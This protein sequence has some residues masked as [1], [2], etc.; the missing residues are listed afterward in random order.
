MINADHDSFIPDI[1]IG[2]SIYQQ[3]LSF[4]KE[5]ISSALNQDGNYSILCTIRVDGLKGCNA[6]TKEWLEQL[7]RNDARVKILFGE[8]NNGTYGSYKEIFNSSESRYICQLDADDWLEKNAIKQ[9][10]DLLEVNPISSFVYTGYNEVNKFGEFVRV[11]ARSEENFSLHRQLVQFNT[12]HLRVIRR[13]YYKLIDGY[14]ENLKF[15]GDYDLSLKLAEQAKPCYLS[16]IL[17]NYR[18]HGSNTSIR[19]KELTIKEA[20]QVASDALK[21]REQEHIWKLDY[22]YDQKKNTQ[23]V[24]LSPR[25][26][27]II[28]AGMH[29]SGTSVLALVLQKM[30]INIGDRLIKADNQNPDGYGEDQ[31]I[32]EINRSALR[33]TTQKSSQ[34]WEDWG[35]TRLQSALPKRH[36]DQIWANQAY[37]Y[38]EQRSNENQF[39]GWKDPRNTLF[40][41]DWVEIEPQSKVV[42]IYR[43]PWEITGALQRIKPPIFL[44]HPDWCLEV[45]NQYNGYLLSFL[46]KYPGRSILV[47]STSLVE[48]PLALVDLIKQ[49]W[50][51]PLANL[52]NSH[53]L[54]I[55]NLI[56]PN[57]Y[58]KLDREEELI[59]LF[60]TCSPRSVDIFKRLDNI[61]DLPSPLK[62]YDYS[63]MMPKYSSRQQI[64]LSIII[65][66]YNQG[67]MLIEALASAEKYRTLN[68]SEVLIVDDGSSDFRTC[69]VLE[70]LRNEG[71]QI[72]RQK[73]QGVSIARNKGLRYAKGDII[74]YLDDDNRLLSPYLNEGLDVMLKNQDLDVV[75]GDRTEFG[76]RSRYIEVG[77]LNSEALWSGNKIDNCALIRRRYLE[78]CGGYCNQLAGFGFEDWDL[79]LSGLS[80]PEGIKLSYLNEA[81]FEYR[82]RPD[83]MVGKLFE[84]PERLEK[85]M[86][87]LSEKYGKKLVDINF[88]V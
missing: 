11:G 75:Y 55:Q 13:T 3:P 36:S 10:I 34:C 21:R 18:L 80:H 44:S 47:N 64:L 57:R 52:T 41:E 33:R 70:G 61:A 7:S 62:R 1:Q 32:V 48:N 8:D 51:W 23:F 37:K 59:K 56:R 39:W 86:N 68:N 35:W 2:I 69:E 63:L 30:G 6:S 25:K 9:C 53:E 72:I 29:R 77:L 60:M 40:L 49:K 45:W 78:R 12:F 43:Y 73:N 17:Y 85:V 58:H 4:I 54:N 19:K 5:C 15:T 16:A 79:W 74:L 24:N 22:R 88:S 14:N 65:T 38:L 27:P 42:G 87:I 67:D 66:S 50:G 26:G 31:S 83:S 84:N 20:F 71:F 28:I 81:C 76:L 82:V 46:Q